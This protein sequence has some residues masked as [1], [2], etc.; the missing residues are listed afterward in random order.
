[1]QLKRKTNAK[2]SAVYGEGAVTDR[3]CQKWFAKFWAGD[4]LLNN[5]PWSSR[6]VEVDSNQ[7]KT[8]IKNNQHYTTWEIADIL[9]MSKS[10]VMGE[11]EKCVF[12][13][14][15]KHIWTFWSTQYIWNTLPPLSYDVSTSGLIF[16]YPWPYSL[17]AGRMFHPHSRR[18]YKKVWLTE[19]HSKYVLL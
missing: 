14:M 3:I 18:D 6:P 12:D 2:V 16:Q 11:N 13:F 9:K 8:L 4:F 5:A 1:M 19:G 15:E 10:I 7:I 17:E